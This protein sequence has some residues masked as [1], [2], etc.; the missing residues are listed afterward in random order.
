DRVDPAGDGHPRTMLSHG[1][2]VSVQRLRG[3][4]RPLVPVGEGGYPSGL[5]RGAVLSARHLHERPLLPA[6]TS[7]LVR[8]HAL[9]AAHAALPPNRLRYAWMNSSR[10]PSITR[11]TS[12]TFT[13]VRW[14]LT[15]VYGWKTYDR[16]WLPQELSVLVASTTARAASCSSSFF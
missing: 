8:A 1:V 15:M 3:G 2:L 10:S 7:A 11:W 13:S 14:S 4:V 9:A 5:E 12:P 16:I 6:R